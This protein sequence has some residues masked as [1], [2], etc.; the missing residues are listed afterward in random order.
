MQKKEI[1]IHSTSGLT[2]GMVSGMGLGMGTSMGIGM[3]SGV[4]K[5]NTNFK[6]SQYTFKASGP[7][8]SKN[9]TTQSKII[10]TKEQSNEQYINGGSDSNMMN[11]GVSMNKAIYGDMRA[12]VGDESQFRFASYNSLGDEGNQNMIKLRISNRSENEQKN[13]YDKT[14]KALAYQTN[15][16][17]GNG[18]IM[19]EKRKK[20][21]FIREDPEEKN[22]LKI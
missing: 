12:K 4:G 14:V 10:S 8:Y 13:K 5:G 7:T 6:S 18:K 22:F 20:I 11:A 19:I 9:I 1:Q 2:S 3:D 17:I 16:E 15:N 21:E